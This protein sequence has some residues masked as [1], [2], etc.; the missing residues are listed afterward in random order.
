MSKGIW[1]TKEDYNTLIMKDRV[2]IYKKGE[3]HATVYFKQKGGRMNKSDNLVTWIATT[4]I[5][6][7]FFVGLMSLMAD[8]GGWV[9]PGTLIALAIGLI[10]FAM[11][12]ALILGIIVGIRRIAR[13]RE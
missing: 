2:L 8:F 6:L 7:F 12:L 4:I 9:V 3:D 10:Y 1:A 5:C 13:G 11:V